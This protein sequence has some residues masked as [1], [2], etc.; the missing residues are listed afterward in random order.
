M[1][2]DSQDVQKNLDKTLKDYMITRN[3]FDQ[4]SQVTYADKIVTDTIRRALE[5]NQYNLDKSVMD[6]DLKSIALKESYLYS[7]IEGTVSAINYKEGETVNSQNAVAAVTITKPGAISFEAMAEDTDILKIN[8][9]N[10]WL[11]KINN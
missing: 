9:D 1:A 5:N 4:T 11:M 6:V 2:L 8:K 7:P 3:N 10:K